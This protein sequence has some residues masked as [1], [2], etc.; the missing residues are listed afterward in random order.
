MNNIKKSNS[1]VSAENGTKPLV[2]SRFYDYDKR[3]VRTFVRYSECTGKWAIECWRKKTE[4]ELKDEF[5][6]LKIPIDS[7]WKMKREGHIMSYN[8]R[9]EAEQKALEL[10]EDVCGEFGF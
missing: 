7:N 2:S 8:S 10:A 9:Q 5:E 6:R 1:D 3:G 4:Q